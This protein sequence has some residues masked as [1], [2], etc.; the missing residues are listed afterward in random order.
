MPADLIGSVEACEVLDID[1]S[2]LTRWLA[3]GRIEAAHK[4]PG[5]SGA[6]LFERSYIECIA[7]QRRSGHAA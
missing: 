6:Y 1:R 5:K 7:D 3:A 2:T 4:M